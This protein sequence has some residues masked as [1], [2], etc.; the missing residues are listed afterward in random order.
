MSQVDVVVPC[1]NYGRFLNNCVD[2][3]LSQE[4]VDVRVLIID[5]ASTDDTPDVGRRLAALDSRVEFHRHEVNQGHIATYNEGLL[6]WAAAEY[7]MLLSA[8]DALSTGAL[9]R[10]T[11][12]MDRHG[13]VGMTYGMA[14]VIAEHEQPAMNGSVVAVFNEYQV[15]S[16]VRFLQ[17]CCE[18]A[19]NPIPTPTVIV[20]TELQRNIGG[21]LADYPH[22][23]DIEMWM[24]FAIQA[25][26]GILGAVQGYYR[27]HGKNMSEGYYGHMLADRR[28][29]ARTCRNVLAVRA[30][31]LPESQR[32]LRAMSQAMRLYAAH[33][34]SHVFDRGDLDGF[35]AWLEF[36]EEVAPGFRF[37][38]PWW[39]LKAKEYLGQRLWQRLRPVLNDICGICEDTSDSWGVVRWNRRGQTIGWW[40][41]PL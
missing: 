9:A 20:R 32:W 14:I 3:I 2:S 7:S 23:G 18:H 16:G 1:Y 4:G 26:V 40:P 33:S 41:E 22:T 29:F 25:D 17:H 10:A 13:Q 36:A 6:E 37:S 21:Y 31:E 28:E 24:R 12:L 15:I 30:T 27:W 38:Y 5:D 35:H 19:Y 8:D 34:A 39:R 11:R